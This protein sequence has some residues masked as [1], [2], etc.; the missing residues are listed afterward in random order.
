MAKKAQSISPKVVIVLEG[1][2]I[3][4]KS[5]QPGNGKPGQNTSYDHLRARTKEVLLPLK[6]KFLKKLVTV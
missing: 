6:P 4:P 3:L 1:W 5:K 2:M